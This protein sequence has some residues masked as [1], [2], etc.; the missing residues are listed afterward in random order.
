MDPPR[1]GPLGRGAWNGDGRSHPLHVDRAPHRRR[2]AELKKSGKG[3]FKYKRPPGDNVDDTI[4]GELGRNEDETG[5]GGTRSSSATS[6]PI[7][8]RSAA[9]AQEATSGAATG[10]GTAKRR[11]PPRGLPRLPLLDSS[12]SHRTHPT[13]PMTTP[14][15]QGIQFR[16]PSIFERGAKGRSGASLAKLDVPDV[17]PSALFGSFARKEAAALPEVSRPRPSGTSSASRS[18]TSAST[19][20]CTRS[21]PAR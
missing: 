16:E 12:R 18:G 3:Y 9:A 21:G 5:E 19:R 14:Q 8:A 2:R 11:G 7:S 15:P 20:S 10:T 4:A 17:D 13:E 6:S 1:Q